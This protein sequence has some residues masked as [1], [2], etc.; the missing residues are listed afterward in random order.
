MNNLKRKFKTT[1]SFIISSKII[2]YLEINLTKKENDS[3]SESYKIVL[4]EIKEKHK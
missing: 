1:I 4:E 2:K 3:Y